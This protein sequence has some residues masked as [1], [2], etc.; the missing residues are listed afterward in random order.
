MPRVAPN[1]DAIFKAYDVRGLYPEQ[2]DE[3]VARRVGRAFVTFLAAREIVIGRDMRA[4]SPQLARAFAEGASQAGAAVVDLGL[5]STDALYFASGRLGLPGAMFT[6]SHNPAQYNGI[7]L[8]RERAAPI[9]AESG[10]N[11]I[12]LLAAETGADGPAVATVQERDLLPEYAAHCRGF[13]DTGKLRPLK[14]A[15]DA[16]NGM[17][18]KTVPLVFDGLPFEIVPLYFDLDGTFPNHPANPIEPENLV[19]LQKAVASQGCDVGIAFDGDADRMFLVDD[20]TTLVSGS[21]TTALVAE[22]LLKAH[23]GETIIHNLICSWVVREVIEEN[24]GRPVRTRVGHS[25]IKAVMAE[26]GA[27]FGGEHS[28]HYYFRENFRAD[29][30][31]IAALIVLEAMSEAEQPLSELLDPYRRYSASGEINSVVDD[32]QEALERL[33]GHY[34]D[35]TQDRTD[36]LTVEYEDWWFNCRPSN[37]EPLLRLNLEART[38]H[39]MKQRRDEVLDVINGGIDE[40]RPT[41]A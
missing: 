15:I 11:D 24:G 35:G 14:V 26:T 37:T 38:E 28:G 8:C 30:G 31:I 32:Q 41:V 25:F 10:L 34:G 36:G 29:S 40:H 7:K 27:I 19:D 12:R 33:A 4:S 21:L 39:L 2:L 13:V 3:D 23:P 6:A 1:I 5:V 20:E 9:G 18:G 16:G 22:R 17:A